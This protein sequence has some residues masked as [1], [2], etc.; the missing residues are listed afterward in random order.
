MEEKE[1]FPGGWNSQREA[2][3]TQCDSGLFEAFIKEIEMIPG[4]WN[5][6]KGVSNTQSDPC[7][8]LRTM[9]IICAFDIFT[10]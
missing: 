7:L 10:N 9:P 8:D 5:S 2:N 4:G 3:N 1:K 6:H